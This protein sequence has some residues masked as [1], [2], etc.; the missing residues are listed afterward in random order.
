[1]AEVFRTSILMTMEDIL[2]KMAQQNGG[3]VINVFAKIAVLP[4]GT[5]KILMHKSWPDKGNPN[6]Y[7]KQAKPKKQKE[8]VEEITISNEGEVEL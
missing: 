8:K 3:S 4:N 6:Q 7:Q 1:M 2:Q 5:T